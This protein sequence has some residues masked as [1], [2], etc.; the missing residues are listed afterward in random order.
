VTHRPAVRQAGVTLAE[1]LV[2]IA[3]IG[4]AATIAIPQA[5]PLSPAAADAAAAEIARAIRFAQREAIR[6]STYQMVSADPATQTINVY[7]VVAKKEVSAIHPVNKTSYQISFAGNAMPRATIVSSVFKYEGGPTT[8]YAS[9]G[10]DGAPA[11]I[12][13]NAVVQFVNLLIG[14]QQVDI[15]PLQEEG[16]ITIRYGSAERVVR[17]APITGRV[18]F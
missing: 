18:T 2:V 10:P 3:V 6:T 8:N 12:D 15:D 16:R 14:T 7:Q 13:P 4:V 17:V 11:Y 5:S 9:F 1:M